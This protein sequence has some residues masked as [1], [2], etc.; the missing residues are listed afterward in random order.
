MP[1]C[2]GAAGTPAV[3][4]SHPVRLCY[5]CA[6][7][8]VL[9]SP[10][11]WPVLIYVCMYV[12][13][14]VYIQ[15]LRY[16]AVPPLGL[17]LYMYVCMYVCVCIYRSSGTRQSLPLACTCICMYVCM[18]VCVYIYKLRY[19]AVPPFG[20]YLYMCVC[21]YVCVCIYISSGTRQSLPL[22]CTYICVYV[23]MYVCVYI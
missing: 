9:C 23:C 22:A 1:S 8:Q 5:G 4:R 21:M 20:L 15:K 18:Y 16:Q 17:Y 14:C 10:S 6:A 12:C 3:S 13:V 19:Q 11:P 2:R 7:A